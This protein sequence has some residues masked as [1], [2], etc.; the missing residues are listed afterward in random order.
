MKRRQ[1]LLG[2]AGLGV[3]LGVATASIAQR[4]TKIPVIGLLDGGERTFWWAAF[5]KQMRD[6]G[7][8]EG[9]NITLEARYAKGKLQDLAALAQDLVR[10][11]AS[12]IVTAAT[13]ATQAAKTAT[14]RIPIVTA[15]GS[16]HVSMGFAKSLA[17]PGGNVT[18]MASISSDLTIKRL[19]LLR[20]MLPGISRLA[21]LWQ[22]DNSGS[23]T[24][25]RDLERATQ[26]ARVTLQN[27][28]I[29][30]REDIPGAFSAAARERV[31][32]VFVI[33][34]P[35]TTD[36]RRQIAELGLKHKM[37]IMATGA[38]YPDVGVLVSYGADYYE[39]F[40]RAAIYVDKIL[41]GAKPGD[42]PIEQAS[43]FEMVINRKSA[44]SLGIAI[45]QAVLVRADRV[46]D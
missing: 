31:Q 20:E 4:A 30:K 46:I 9:K 26:S 1:A 2:I 42:L 21:V 41:K 29:R 15:T 24:A 17:R 36:E 43:K 32:A 33:G 11:D 37:P 25:M 10:R 23:I 7:Y 34:G 14:D 38:E 40:R 19:E 28:G 6:L 45:P 39:L 3:G 16:D 13:I 5:R 22:M 12:V 27:I 44:K 35:L 8:A 18:G